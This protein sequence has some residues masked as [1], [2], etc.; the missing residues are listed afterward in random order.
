MWRKSNEVKPSEQPHGA[1]SEESAKAPA[2]QS[3]PLA[4]SSFAPTAGPAP[5]SSN[6]SRIGS[7]LKIQ[8]EVSGDSDLYID[9]DVRGKVQLTN[10]R[11][12]VGPNGRVQAEIEARQIC[13]EGTVQGDLRA[14]E[15]AQLGASSRVRGNVLSPRIG[16]AD[17]AQLSG[18]IETT[19]SPALETPERENHRETVGAKLEST[20]Q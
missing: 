17:G 10:S 5:A 8:G 19:K 12:T 14:S 16:V 9:G 13:V 7:G 3:P 11:V 6:L 20:D 2:L 1:R 4:P 18:K 15:S